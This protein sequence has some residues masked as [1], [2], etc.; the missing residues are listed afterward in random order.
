MYYIKISTLLLQVI[1]KIRI[2]SFIAKPQVNKN[3]WYN[4]DESTCFVS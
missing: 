2:L 1:D 4:N 3:V